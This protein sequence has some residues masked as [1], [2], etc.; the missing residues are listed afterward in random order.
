M[1]AK[2][3]NYGYQSL[4][5]VYVTVQRQSDDFFLQSDGSFGASSAV[6]PMPEIFGGFYQYVDNVE[7]WD[8]GNY[9]VLI[10]LNPD[11]LF[12]FVQYVSGNTQIGFLEAASVTSKNTTSSLLSKISDQQAAI[13]AQAK[14][15]VILGEK[16]DSFQSILNRGIY[17]S[18]TPE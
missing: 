8:T 9:N 12:G 16:I 14:T 15:I 7:A 2:I 1:A 17:H 3:F 11:G 18:S 6:I 10:N 13:D 5:S 4:A